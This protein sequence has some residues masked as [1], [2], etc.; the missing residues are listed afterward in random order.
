MKEREFPDDERE[1]AW[2][3]ASESLQP[4]LA[5]ALATQD[6]CCHYVMV[7]ANPLLAVCFVCKTAFVL[8]P[9]ATRASWAVYVRA[10]GDA[11]AVLA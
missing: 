2:E 9:G 7:R 8:K 5:G 3:V 10:A 4:A 1:E 11:E 6:V